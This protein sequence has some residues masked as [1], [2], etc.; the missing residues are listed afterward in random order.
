VIRE[1]RSSFGSRFQYLKSDRPRSSPACHAV[2]TRRRVTFLLVFVPRFCQKPRMNTLCR[3]NLKLVLAA[4]ALL[5][6][7]SSTQ[8]QTFTL[9]ADNRTPVPGGTG[10]FSGF[11]DN[12]AI[13]Q[14]NVVFIGWDSQGKTGIYSFKNGQLTIV[15]DTHTTVP[16]T[17]SLF[18]DFNDVDLARSRIAFTGAWAGGNQGVFLQTGQNALQAWATTATTGKKYFQGITLYQRKLIV[19]GGVNLV[20]SFGNHSE[21]VMS[22]PRQDTTRVLLD[23]NTPKPE[24]GTFVGYDQTVKLAA[25]G[26]LFTEIIPNTIPTAAGIYEIPSGSSVPVLVANQQTPVPNGSGPF[27][28]YLGIDWDGSEVAFSGLTSL[29]AFLYAATSPST[30]RV[31]ADKSTAM[32]DGGFFAGVA[33][34]VAYEGG[35]FVF[36]GYGGGGVGLFI[37]QNGVITTVLKAGD[38]LNGRTVSD[39]FCYEGGKSGNHLVIRVLYTDFS[40]GLYLVDLE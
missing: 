24:G 31:I 15:A 37:S 22:I 30:V 29:G 23:T 1:L 33:N 26:L 19:T 34:P 7:V 38:Q 17:T 20:D 10:T 32:P 25:T 12:R 11:Y 9:I 35:T 28:G 3:P 40:S 6:E 36:E 8:A 4:L 14:G 16:G 18:S 39:A 5:V 27:Q 21:S 13:H 2:A